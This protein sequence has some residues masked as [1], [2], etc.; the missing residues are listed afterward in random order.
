VNKYLLSI[1]FLFFVGAAMAQKKPTRIQIP[2]YD[3]IFTTKANGTDLWKVYKATF[4]QDNTTLRSDSAYFYPTQNLCDAFGHVVITQGDTLHIFGDK[5]HYDG[6][7]KIAIMTDHV[8]MVDK[9]A[10]LTTNYLTYN[11]AIRVGTY[12]G[13]GKLVNQENTLTSKNGYYF[14]STRDAYFRYDVVMITTDAIIK[15]DTLRYNSGTG[16]SYFYGPT[17]I[18]AKKDKD[19]LYTENGTYD[20][21]TEQ[22]FFGKKNLYT[23]GTKSLK[24]DSLFYDRLTGYGKALKHI[25]FN[26]EQQKVT[27]KGDKAVYT[28][29]DERTVVTENAYVVLET[30]G[31]TTQKNDTVISKPVATKKSLADSVGK[32]VPHTMKKIDVDAKT[33]KPL[34]IKPPDTLARASLKKDTVKNTRDSIFMASDT[35]ETQIVTRKSELETREKRRLYALR[36]TSIKVVPSIVYTKAPKVL[37]AP[38]ARIMIDSTSFM[39]R[40]Y[41]PKPPRDT[42]YHPPK[43]VA[44]KKPTGKVL[45]PK[46][47]PVDSVNLSQNVVLP[48][49]AKVRILIAYHH[50]KIYKSD[51]QA[52]ADSIFYSYSDSTARMYRSPMVWSN[53]SQLSGDTITLQFKN[54]KADNITLSPHAF[55]VNVVKTDSVHF[56]QVGGRKMRGFFKDGKI[57]KV[58]VDGNAETIYYQRDSLDH[59]TD[60]TRTI[61][62][63]IRVNFYKGELAA[64]MLTVKTVTKD[65]PLV[66]IKEEDKI[67]KGFIWKPKDRPISKE[68][69]IPSSYTAKPAAKKE[70]QKAGVKKKNVPKP[71]IKGTLPQPDIKKNAADTTKVKADTLKKPVSKPIIIKPGIAEPN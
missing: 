58:F 30:G 56:N 27:I 33:G 42:S 24:G 51:L 17:H 15:T 61:S 18:Y 59:A 35:I 7:T 16:I 34:A 31:D 69:I 48:D 71:A 55:V 37:T 32:P 46:I 29:P 12:T 2:H 45:P 40:D 26:D 6:N 21:K 1:L 4:Q 19:V 54:K 9:D 63:K 47:I 8:K 41:F 65:I 66:A 49:T 53:G 60:M 39:H 13:G 57:D 52:R 64:T 44:P 22:A 68:S 28:K 36:D 20:T 38:S 62:S 5:L 3:S 25:T 70:G 67:L 14:A 11:T 23:S 50:A 10:T 43:K